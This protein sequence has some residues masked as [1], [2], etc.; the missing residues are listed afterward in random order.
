VGSIKTELAFHGDV[1]N[2]AARIEE[3]CKELNKELLIS[4]ELYSAIKW[5]ENYQLKQYDSIVLKGKKEN[6]TLYGVE[7]KN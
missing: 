4:E 6:V 2:V 3:K 5:S 1:I 7:I